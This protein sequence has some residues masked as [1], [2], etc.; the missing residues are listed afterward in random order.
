VKVGEMEGVGVIVGV[1]EGMGE[2]VEE[3][4]L[5]RVRVGVRVSVMVLE[6]EPV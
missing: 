4:E 3:G 1:A 2:F 5:V 6:G